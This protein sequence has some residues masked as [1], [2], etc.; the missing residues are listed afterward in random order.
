MGY[1]QSGS[2]KWLYTD[3]FDNGIIIKDDG[4]LRKMG[5]SQVYDDILGD[6]FSKKLA[7]ANGRVDY[8]WEEN[9]IKFQDSG[10]IDD[11]NKRIQTN[12]QFPHAATL[13]DDA[14]LQYHFHWFQEDTTQRDLTMAYRLQVNGEEKVENWT[15]LTVS[16]NNGLEIFPYITG[17]TL[18]QITY[19]PEIDVSSVG[20]STTIQLRIARQDSN[21]DLIN[22]SFIDAHVG[23][24]SDGSQSQWVK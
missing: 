6:L 24:D 4:S 11:L 3:D 17:T 9:V 19:F 18:N 21:G 23:I 5:T 20:I 2:T 12:M 15:E 16:T 13:G 1:I 7:V 14:F 10:D 22:I 8:D